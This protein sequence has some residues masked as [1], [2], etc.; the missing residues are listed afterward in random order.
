M[1]K[2][3][4]RSSKY[5]IIDVVRAYDKPVMSA[6]QLKEFHERVLFQKLSESAG[7]S[8]IQ[9]YPSYDGE[10]KEKSELCEMLSFNNF[11]SLITRRQNGLLAEKGE[12]SL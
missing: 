3:R 6:S 10:G 5:S 8:I 9:A 4:K 2:Q 12:L 11:C 7:L 1:F